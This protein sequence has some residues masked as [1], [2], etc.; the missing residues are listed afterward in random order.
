[1]ASAGSD[2]I[3]VDELP[4]FG[5]AM[6][7]AAANC[8]IERVPVGDLIDHATQ[9]SKRDRADATKKREVWIGNGTLF[10]PSARTVERLEPGVYAP[11][12]TPNGILIRKHKVSVDHLIDTGDKAAV[13]LISEFQQFWAKRDAFKAHGFLHKRG[14]LLWGPPGSGKTSLLHVMMRELIEKHSGLVVLMDNHPQIIIEGLHTIREIEPDRQIIGVIEDIDAIVQRFGEDSL[15]SLLDGE[16][17]VDN[18]SFVATT[19]YPERLDKRLVNRPSRFDTIKLI[20]MPSAQARDA[21]LKAKAMN[22]SDEDRAHWVSRTDGFSMAHLKEVIV[23]VECFGQSF[24]DVIK[25]IDAM[26]AKLSSDQADPDF[27]N[28][29]GFLGGEMQ[30]KRRLH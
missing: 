27:G 14:Y 5:A 15:L 1:M 11:I 18:I 2:E 12:A 9:E 29:A 17:Q 26:R 7:A 30:T 25:R 6:A 19:N 23:A 20:S 16:A 28:G 4:E 24:E 21:Y 3:D 8:A 22:L 10:A 13:E